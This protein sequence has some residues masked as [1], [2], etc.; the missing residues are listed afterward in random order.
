MLRNRLAARI[1]DL[2]R[3]NRLGRVTRVVGLVIEAA[4]IDVGLSEL[5]RVTSLSEAK[6]VLAEVVGFHER[7]VLLMPLGDIDGLHPGSSVTPLGRSFGVDVGPGLL[8]R[9]L[10]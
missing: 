1:G 8:G 5:C 3:T 4:G 6:S 9:V 7:G 2:P 10:N